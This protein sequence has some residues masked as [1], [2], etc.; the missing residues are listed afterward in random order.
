MAI[1]KKGIIEAGFSSVVEG[2]MEDTVTLDEYLIENKE[3]AYMLRVETDSMNDAG[4]LRGDLIIVERGATPK[5]GDIIVALI[6]GHY[7]IQHFHKNNRDELQVEAVVKSV[8]RKY[9]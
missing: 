6:D 4:I 8:V 5:S 9:K 1:I 2:E 7:H 3:S